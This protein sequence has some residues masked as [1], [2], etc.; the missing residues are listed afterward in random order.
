[1]S[2]QVIEVWKKIMLPHKIFSVKMKEVKKI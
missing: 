1:M 2:P